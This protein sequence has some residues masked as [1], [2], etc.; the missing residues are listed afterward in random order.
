MYCTDKCKY[1]FCFNQRNEEKKK[2]N[3]CQWS[4]I[5]CK[6]KRYANMYINNII[7]PFHLRLQI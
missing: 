4:M 3:D 6:L 5:V 7:T 2:V 1:L